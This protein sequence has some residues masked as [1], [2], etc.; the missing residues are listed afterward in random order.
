MSKKLLDELP[1]QQQTSIQ[2]NSVSKPHDLFW[3][4]KP[5]KLKASH[6]TLSADQ[7]AQL[8]L[9]QL[10]KPSRNS[11]N[12]ISQEKPEVMLKRA[13]L[14]AKVAINSLNQMVLDGN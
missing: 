8:V 5:G 12:H 9:N 11:L 6:S 14:D 1:Y 4:A 3:K 2:L 10:N 7:D 13:S